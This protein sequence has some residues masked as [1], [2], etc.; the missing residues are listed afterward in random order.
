[1]GAGLTSRYLGDRPK[2]GDWWYGTSYCWRVRAR[3][4]VMF[5][6]EPRTAR[7]PVAESE[8]AQ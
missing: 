2:D 4:G 5:G 6:G 3:F 7:V 1:M 8:G